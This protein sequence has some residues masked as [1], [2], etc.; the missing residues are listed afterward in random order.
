M[1]S[2]IVSQSRSKAITGLGFK[3][4]F[5]WYKCSS[6]S[7]DHNSIDSTRGVTNQLRPNTNGYG[8]N[9][10]DQIL[11]LD[12]D[13]FTIG[14]GGDANQSGQEY[15]AWCWKA[16]GGTT[17]TNND[18]GITSTVQ[19]NTAAG[20]SIVQYTG[21]GSGTQ[22]VGHGLGDTPDIII[23]K[24]TSSTEDWYVY[25]PPPTRS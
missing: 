21:T 20:F 10:T 11:S 24:R 3:P 14:N 7:F 8:Y 25:F 17:T 1:V 6:T 13:G 19:A 9:A 15:V 18:G 12:T 4:D 23:Q 2:C 16:A 5:V 22:T